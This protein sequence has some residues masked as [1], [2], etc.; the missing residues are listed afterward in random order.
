MRRCVT[1]RWI[2]VRGTRWVF[3][4]R[5]ISGVFFKKGMC[6]MNVCSAREQKR[7]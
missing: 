5:R 2:R 1:R 3:E 4:E 6:V 7:V